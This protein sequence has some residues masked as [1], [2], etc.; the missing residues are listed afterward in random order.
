MPGRTWTSN[1]AQTMGLHTLSLTWLIFKPTTS[2]S[3][4]FSCS[5]WSC[6]LSRLFCSLRARNEWHRVCGTVALRN[7][8]VYLLR[9]LTGEGQ[10]YWCM[11][12]AI[13]SQCSSL[14]PNWLVHK[15][16]LAWQP[17]TLDSGHDDADLVFLGV[18][19]YWVVAIFGVMICYLNYTAWHTKWCI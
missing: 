11:S 3:W 14:L 15:A 12:F 10:G 1:P 19:L 6:S 13:G 7:C 2:G 18:H 4:T 8:P 16:P 17:Y 5:R 9:T